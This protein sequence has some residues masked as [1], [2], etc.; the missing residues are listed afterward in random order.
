MIPRFSIL[1]LAVL[2]LLALPPG[3]AAQDPSSQLWGDLGLVLP[4]N[5]AEWLFSVDAKPKV[6]F[7]GSE[8]WWKV[9][10]QSTAVYQ[11][12]RLFD[13]VGDLM[14]GFTKQNDDVETLELVPRVGIRVHLI[15]DVRD[16]RPVGRMAQRIGLATT[17]RLEHRH[18]WYYGTGAAT[19]S[20]N[21]WR[22]RLRLE[23]RI[24]LNSADRSRPG[25]W[26]LFADAEAFIPLGDRNPE[27]FANEWRFRVG[28]GFRSSHAWQFDL[29]YIHDI[30]RN[31]LQDSFGADVNAIDLRATHYLGYSGGP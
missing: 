22:L 29:L 8:K 15:S 4:R 25:T 7:S 31:T 10:L 17:A 5:N 16:V 13:L 3:A 20:S 14:L 26:F 9:N 27:T 6:Q 11:A 12:P 21:D 23:T 30:T 24:G 28:P 18:F 19:D 1:F 2:P